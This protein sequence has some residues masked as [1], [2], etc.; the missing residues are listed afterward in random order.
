MCVY[1]RGI[2]LNKKKKNNKSLNNKK[3]NNKSLNN[4]IK[5]SLISTNNNQISDIINNN[6]N[7]YKQN[8]IKEAILHN[9]PLEDKLNVIIVIS[10]PC[11][12][13]R[14]YILAKQFIKRIELDEQY[15]N[16][17]IVELVYNNQKYIL[18]D[19]E[20]KNHLQIKTAIPIWHK[21]NMINLG[22]KYLLPSNWKAF[23][24]I[25]ADI[26][27]D[28]PM[29]ALDT[30]KVL[31]GCKDIVQIFSHCIDMA[32]NESTMGFITSFGYQYCKN[33]SLNC[34]DFWHPG[35]AWACTRETYEKMNGLFED[36][37]LGSG[38]N[39]MALS[40]INKGLTVLDNK[41]TD[42][43]KLKVLE[44]QK[45]IKNARLGY[46]PGIIR[47][48][49]HGSK[50]NRKYIKR[51]EILVKYNFDPNL[52]LTKDE[53]GILIPTKECPKELLKEIFNY[54]KERKEDD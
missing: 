16:L 49:Y 29:W 33:K 9:T 1:L 54:F 2:Y 3:L 42:G 18:T 47:H 25:D 52:H 5:N 21:E 7:I 26:E 38:D 4:K 41:S 37:I 27:F 24:W 17:Y 12:Y 53:M 39:I 15:V 6:N 34:N 50:R 43:Y 32:N 36:A 20:N 35:Y 8:I 22:V 14:S 30:L 13:K 44:L 23:A 10:N 40:L 48:Y 31:N 28:N 46:I 11:L 51:R 19:N 45:N